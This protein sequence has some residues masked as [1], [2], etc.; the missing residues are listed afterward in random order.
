MPY[1]NGDVIGQEYEVLRVLGAGGFGTVYLVYSRKWRQAF[2]LKTFKDEF[3]RD[4]ANRELFR[5]EATLWINI[6]SHPCIV[7]AL[8][9]EE[10]HGRLYLAL[11][12]VAADMEGHRSHSLE[13]V[14]KTGALDLPRALLWS[15][16]VCH[17]MEFA[18]SRGIR[19]HRDIK[20]SNILIHRSFFAK[21]SDFGL[22]GALS[23]DPRSPQA[24]VTVQGGGV[25]LS[26]QSAHGVGVG[27]PTHMPPEQYIDAA[28]CDERS[29]IYSFGVVLFQMATGA[30]PFLAPPPRADSEE[31]AIRF[32]RD[33]FRL[34]CDAPVP[35]LES[36]LNPII[37]RCL[38]KKPEL[39][40]Q[41]FAE[42][43]TDLEPFLREHDPLSASALTEY[44]QALPSPT[45]EH[46]KASEWNNRGVSM[47]VLGRVEEAMRCYTRALELDPDLAQAW[48]NKAT[49]LE[50]LSRFDEALDCYGK[51][52]GIDPTNPKSWSSKAY[53]LLLLGRW[54]EALE[55]CNHALELDPKNMG[56]WLNKGNILISTNRSSEA[57]DCLRHC[58]ELDPEEPK[59]WLQ[60]GQAHGDLGHFEDALRC[61]RRALKV[62]PQNFWVWEGKGNAL[63]SLDRYDEALVCFQRAVE[64]DPESASA[65]FKK[66]L[67]EDA[68][69]HCKAAIQSFRRFLSVAGERLPAQRDHAHRRLANL[70]GK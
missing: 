69:G 65:L 58:L 68:L 47:R 6:G 56:V 22:A 28:S 53:C 41:S 30:L 12:Y 64:I 38:Q 31:E 27:M 20:P 2:A 55:C 3:L 59:A 4:D 57:L 43:R 66:A 35:R 40:Y 48:A 11:E 32:T 18:Y 15:I 10:I 8:F 70:E 24:K 60:M 25:G 16:F 34:H 51:A 49:A 29:D 17:G 39:R 23:I 21:V 52:L 63:A 37:Q 54:E 36:P 42:L 7:Q 44:E 26:F 9:V 67:S 5:K 50:D 45:T 33:M 1:A 62:D 46:L 19:C 14:L 13:E 61:F